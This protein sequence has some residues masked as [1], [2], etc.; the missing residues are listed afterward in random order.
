MRLL[1]ALVLALAACSG[2]DAPPATDAPVTDGGAD[3]DAG[4]DA[5]KGHPT[6]VF[7]GDTHLHTSFSMDAGLFGATTTPDDAYRFAR[8]E[9]IGVHPHDASGE[10]LRQVQLAL[11]HQ[12]PSRHD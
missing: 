8:G 5:P 9:A 4:K 11:R 2:G 7:F 3:A 6:Q 12:S 10:P 1:S